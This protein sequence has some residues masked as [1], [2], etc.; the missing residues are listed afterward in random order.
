[1]PKKTAS[2]GTAGSPASRPPSFLAGAEQ[3]PQQDVI[4][5][6]FRFRK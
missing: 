2:M 5:S 3:A 6:A 4:T 1:M